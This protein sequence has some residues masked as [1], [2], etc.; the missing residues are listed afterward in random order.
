M[1]KGCA[2]HLR[3]PPCFHCKVRLLGWVY[4]G[5]E[6]PL[7]ST[8][9]NPIDPIVS[10]L[11]CAEDLLKTNEERARLRDGDQNHAKRR[12]AL[13]PYPTGGMHKDN[14]IHGWIAEIKDPAESEIGRKWNGWVGWNAET[15]SLGFFTEM[16]RSNIGQN[17]TDVCKN[18]EV[19]VQHL[20]PCLFCISPCWILTIHF[21]MFLS[22][23]LQWPE[24]GNS[25]LM[26]GSGGVW[27]CDHKST[28]LNIC[29]NQQTR[30]TTAN[31]GQVVQ[32]V[33]SE[34]ERF[35]KWIV[36]P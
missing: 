7:S 6:L 35:S 30:I 20:I 1:N 18:Y 22:A 16:F 29:L 32:V 17:T 36:N 33:R 11:Y 9:S 19:I 14:H 2:T 31:G 4:S 23:A 34:E 13:Q 8:K 27:S 25:N 21:V 12:R 28:K 24:A 15:E 10:L 26:R 3:W 5:L